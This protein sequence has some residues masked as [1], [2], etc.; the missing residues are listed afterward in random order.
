MVFN[1]LPLVLL[2]LRQGGSIKEPWGS[3]TRGPETEA[4]VKVKKGQGMTR[5][6]KDKD[7]FRNSDG[8]GEEGAL[9]ASMITLSETRRGQHS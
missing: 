7:S 5:K 6:W 9:F 3:H 2:W 1:Y 4:R 8:E